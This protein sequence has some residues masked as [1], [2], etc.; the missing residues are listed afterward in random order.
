MMIEHYAVAY[1]KFHIYAVNIAQHHGAIWLDSADTEHINGQ[2]SY[3]MCDPFIHYHHRSY[4]HDF[5]LKDLKNHALFQKEFQLKLQA[6]RESYP[7]LPPFIGGFC[8]FMSYEYALWQRFGIIPPTKKLTT[9]PHIYGGIYDCILYADHAKK[10]A[11]IITLN[12]NPN[13]PMQHRRNALLKKATQHFIDPKNIF[14]GHVNINADI[15]KINY[16]KKVEKTI[17]YIKQGDIFQANITRP[18]QVQKPK[19]FNPL[20]TY[21][22]LRDHNKAPFSAYIHHEH[23]NILSASPERFLQVQNNEIT[24]EPIK[25]TIKSHPNAEIDLE[26]KKELKNCPKNR[27]ENI[28]IVDL[29][30]NDIT[31]HAQIGSIKVD[32][33][34]AL[35]SFKGLHHLISTIKAKIKPDAHVIDVIKM[36]LPAGSITGA[37]KKRSCEII[38]EQEGMQRGAYCGHIG[39]IGLDG[40]CDFN[41]LIRTLQIDTQHITLNSGCGITAQSCPTSEWQETCT[42][43]KKIKEIFDNPCI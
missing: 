32:K 6:A 22:H 37:P 13:Q 24:V 14:S 8:G 35:H 34:C 10:N 31:P 21:L 2:Y 19:N 17:A 12:I 36:A 28:M 15:D 25:G 16:T 1:A 20:S 7:N 41:I 26:R 4:N 3:V 9:L 18:I 43:V 23:F 42:K 39:Y 27:A 11:G 5:L 38:Y 29:L 33:L 40:Q 30:R